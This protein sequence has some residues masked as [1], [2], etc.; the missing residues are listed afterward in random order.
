MTLAEARGLSLS[1]LPVRMLRGQADNSLQVSVS[2]ECH[3][4]PKVLCRHLP[5]HRLLRA[6][7]VLL[8]LLLSCRGSLA[9]RPSFKDW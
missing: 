9:V 8:Q 3:L 4:Q 1:S 2:S 7:Q 5:T 6:V